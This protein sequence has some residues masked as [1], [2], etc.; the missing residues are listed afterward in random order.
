MNIINELFN[1]RPSDKIKDDKITIDDVLD[2]CTDNQMKSDLEYINSMMS[3]FY[4]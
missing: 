1:I 4:S 3:N 2:H